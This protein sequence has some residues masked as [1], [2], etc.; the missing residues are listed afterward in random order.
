MMTG[1]VNR[2]LLLWV[3]V[4]ALM[5]SS[6]GTLV[7][8]ADEHAESLIILHTNDIHGRGEAFGKLATL[9]SQYRGGDH[10]VLLLDAGDTFHGI[11]FA[12]VPE[13]A[14]IATLMNAVGYDAMTAGNHDFNYGQSRLVALDGLTDFPILA[15]N[16]YKADG[17][18]LLDP[19]VLVEMDGFTVGIFGLAT[20][21]TLF[22]TH[23]NNVTGLTFAD[24]VSEAAAMVEELKDMAD[25]IIAIGHLGIDEETEYAARSNAVATEVDGI[26]VFVD[27]HSHDL[28]EDGMMAGDTLIVSA[29]YH[30]SHM[31]IVELSI[32]DGQ[33]V[34]TMA[35]VVVVSGDEELEA[36]EAVTEIFAAQQA[37]L[38]E[39]LA[40]PLGSTAVK[41]EGE[42]DFV[43]TGE[44]NL[45]NL[46][47]DVL[48]NASGADIAFTN[49]GGIRASIEAGVITR[50]DVV[51]AF[52]FG[53]N[54][55]V[56]EVTGAV[57]KEILEHGTRAY[58]EASGGFPHVAGMSYQIDLSR[59]VG[60]RIVNLM[61]NGEPIDMEASYLL[62]TN[63]FLAAGGD[64]YTMLGGLPTVARM[65]AMDEALADYLA[66]AGEI[67]PEVESR[68]TVAGEL[69]EAVEEEPAIE[70]PM[71][72]DH[73]T[74]EPETAPMP[75]P[76]SEHGIHVVQPGEVLWRIAQQHHTTWEMLA[77]M[78]QLANPHLIFPGQEIAYPAH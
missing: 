23:P 50:G 42:R 70:V 29:G 76:V 21:E 52:P 62:A 28:L 26:H 12:T 7:V 61:V 22:K 73:M 38:E 56:K 9:V 39:M 63:D 16:V 8:F 57:V 46:I 33:V 65:M 71:M 78:N 3:M 58:P 1:K 64:D 15:A 30:G 6:F 55:E 25:V 17:T 11:P 10:Q 69:P 4:I 68:I 2:K 27:G 44:T 14:S 49:G 75:M 43:R 24:P 51:T 18:R 40:E 48:K 32:V 31:G 77:E 66:A 35:G 34:E 74:D 13:G 67:A 20:P 5:F 45:G 47:A 72:D 19:Y 60:D 59:S 37:E 53:N 36:N 54:I 41:L